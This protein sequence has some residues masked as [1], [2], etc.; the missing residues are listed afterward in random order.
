[1]HEPQLQPQVEEVH[2]HDEFEEDAQM[3]STPDIRRKKL[4]WNHILVD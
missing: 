3:I 4:S 1:V 2:E